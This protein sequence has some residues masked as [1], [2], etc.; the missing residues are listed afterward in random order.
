MTGTKKTND[1]PTYMY[2]DGDRGGF[3]VTNPLTGKSKRFL[4]SEEE[5]AREAAKLL[6][7][8]VETE[9]QQRLLDE[10]K[11]RIFGL[12]D[13]WIEHRMQF[14]PWSPSTREGK[15]YKLERIKRELGHHIVARTDRIFINN[16]IEAFCRNADT[17]NEWRDVFVEL[18]KE[19]CFQKWAEANEPSLIP[20]RST[21]RKI[22]A[23]RKIRRQMDIR[24]F[25]VFHS[26]AP[27]FCQIAM[28]LSFITLQGLSECCNMQYADIRGGYL[29]VIRDKS[30]SDSDMAF[31][32]IAI[33][34]D[35]EDVIR[36]S[37]QLDGG[38][39][40]PY[41]VHRIPARERR[42]WT[43]GK[44][45]WTYVNP[46]YLSKTFSKTR[47]LSGYCDHLDSRQRETFHEI[48]G[49]AGRVY[50]D[51]K[52]L[53][54]PQVTALMTHADESTTKIYL[55]KGPGA[56]TDAHF[57]PVVAPMRFRDVVRLHGVTGVET[58][59]TPI[60]PHDVGSVGEKQG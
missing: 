24:G 42:E 50:V 59:V 46:D 34:A 12:V 21:S 52:I 38:V 48:R 17:F 1:Y 45:H 15:R 36:R 56:L 25:E 16:W 11:P 53:T 4:R 41:L 32:K 20:V 28:E 22:E 14:M 31:I 35:L 44:P 33:T 5:K 57:R 47:D 40:S 54:A 6:K 39:V 43:E 3:R 29:F 27:P 55:E 37:R 51:Q 49:L 7:A 23:N 2:D 19:A 13:H 9:R 18:W 30:S 60:F 26:H 58:N 10:G 8:Y